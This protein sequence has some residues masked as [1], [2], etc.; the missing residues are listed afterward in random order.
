MKHEYFLSTTAHVKLQNQNKPLV[1]WRDVRRDGRTS[2]GEYLRLPRYLNVKRE[3]SHTP[4]RRERI[5]VGYVV[6]E[7]FLK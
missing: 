5:N 2:T 4:F 7:V 3:I 1:V 6:E